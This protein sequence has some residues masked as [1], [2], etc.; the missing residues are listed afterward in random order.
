MAEQTRPGMGLG[1]TTGRLPTGPVT[2]WLCILFFATSVLATISQRKFGIGV[3]DLRFD[4]E[5]LQRL[6]LWRLITYIFAQTKPLEHSFASS[7]FDQI[8]QSIFLLWAFGRSCESSLG[9]REFLRFFLVSA[10]GAAILAVPLHH[11]IN[12]IKPF[13]DIG[14]IEGPFSVTCAMCVAI[15][16]NAPNA[17][18]SLGFMSPLHA[19]ALIGLAVALNM[20][21]V[22]FFGMAPL[23]FT[24]SGMLMGYLLVNRT[25]RPDLLWTRWRLARLRA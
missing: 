4:M 24:L 7:P 12:F 19:R 25:W 23:S 2:H 21:F 1:D 17:Q 10:V 22:A 18:V 3:E 11:L 9:S 16:L 15:A 8:L 14:Y 20:F 6:E 13:A 5:S